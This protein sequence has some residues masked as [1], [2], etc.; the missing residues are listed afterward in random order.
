MLYSKPKK[1]KKNEEKINGIQ[2]KQQK[3]HT[4]IVNHWKQPNQSDKKNTSYT[5]RAIKKKGR[6]N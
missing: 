1:K 5:V 4:V 2:K 3:K 6:K